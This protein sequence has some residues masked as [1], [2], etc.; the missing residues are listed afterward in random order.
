MWTQKTGT[1]LHAHTAVLCSHCYVLPARVVTTS[2]GTTARTALPYRTVRSYCAVQRTVA[3]F[4]V[5]Y[6][7]VLLS[8]L[9][10]PTA[11]PLAAVACSTILR[12]V[13]PCS[14]GERNHST[15]QPR[16]EASTKLFAR[17]KY[18]QSINQPIK[19]LKPI[20]RKKIGQRTH[21]RTRSRTRPL[22][23]ISRRRQN[24]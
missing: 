6:N 16:L 13:L 18:H 20:K 10:Y 11:Y 15:C 3:P 19:P 7:S 12:T 4:C 23:Y 22:L 14:M 5:H 24:P 1:T 17:K 21:E 2:H 9:V 8:R